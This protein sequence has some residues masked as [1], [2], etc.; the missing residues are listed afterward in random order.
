MD[1][2]AVVILAALIGAG[3]SIAATALTMWWTARQA[4]T[5]QAREE[6][7]ELRAEKRVAYRDLV[8]ALNAWREATVEIADGERR[9]KDWD[10]YWEAREDSMRAGA[11]L[12]LVGSDDMIDAASE[13][14][15][16]L[17]DISWKYQTHTE[18]AFPGYTPTPEEITKTTWIHVGVADREAARLVDLMRLDLGFAP[19]TRERPTL[20]KSA[21]MSEPSR[22]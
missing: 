20:P 9:K 15:E 22:E 7:R 5:H 10:A 2:A 19:M 11:A 1:P 18:L 6:G 8:Q 3:S 12:E 13:A 16:T 4:E 17:L 21:T 14:M